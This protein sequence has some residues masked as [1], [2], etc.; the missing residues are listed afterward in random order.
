MMKS[1]EEPAPA[2]EGPLLCGFEYVLYYLFL[3]AVAT[4][5]AAQYSV[6]PAIGGIAGFISSALRLPFSETWGLVGALGCWLAGAILIAWAAKRMSP[7]RKR[8]ALLRRALVLIGSLAVAALAAWLHSVDRNLLPALAFW[9]APAVGVFVL[10][11]VS[12]RWRAILLS[13]VTASAA[14]TI[15]GLILTPRPSSAWAGTDW[16]AFTE[17]ERV[18][19]ERIA[20]QDLGCRDAI[21]V[22]A[23]V[24]IARDFA[25]RIID[26]DILGPGE[27]RALLQ[28]SNWLRLPSHRISLHY[29]DRARVDIRPGYVSACL[30]EPWQ[31]R[32][33][34]LAPW[35]WQRSA[36]GGA[37]WADVPHSPHRQSAETEGY[38]YRYAPTKADLADANTLLRACV[39]IRGG[40]EVCAP[41]V[42]PRP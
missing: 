37:S 14:V 32:R 23:S 40:G 31:S 39:D 26:V 33:A 11:K 25:S 29:T 28:V 4:V 36:D 9:T 30:L 19:A 20:R 8:R 2:N 22:S 10:S 21:R 38:T 5:A 12:A 41:G 42:R 7:E 35:R 3:G 17:Q 16:S 34:P 6:D 13:L 1:G 18:Y 24:K 15:V 27:Y